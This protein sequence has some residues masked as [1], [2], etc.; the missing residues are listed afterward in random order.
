MKS[1]LAKV[2]LVVIA[3]V[4]VV[5]ID[6]GRGESRSERQQSYD[7]WLTKLE[8]QLTDFADTKEELPEVS[9]TAELPIAGDRVTRSLRLSAGRH[10]EILR[11]LSLL[12]E[13]NVFSK[14][15]SD[16]SDDAVA[17]TVS[18]PPRSFTTTLPVTWMSDNIQ[19]SLFLRLLEEYSRSKPTEAL[20]HAE[21]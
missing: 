20:P 11:L 19:A 4:A 5:M 16:P 14:R 21:S 3:I 15:A 18:S 10:H 1:P 6:G 13:A 2:V 8:T 7:A 17:I 9:I 12:R